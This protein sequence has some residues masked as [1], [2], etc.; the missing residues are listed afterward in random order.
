MFWELV[1]FAAASLTMFSFFPQIFKVLK[2]KSAKDISPVMILQ[3]AS[4]VFLWILYGLH[5]KNLIIIL[6]NSVTL[7]SLIV[8]LVLYRLYI[9]R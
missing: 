7:F 4:G 3:L 2:T 5:L 9:K 1:G 6:A 8:L